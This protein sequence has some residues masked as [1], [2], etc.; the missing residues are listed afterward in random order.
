MSVIVRGGASG[1]R[2]RLLDHP[3]GA[4]PGQGRR[5]GRGHHRIGRGAARDRRRARGRRRRCVRGGQRHDRPVGR[6]RVDGRDLPAH[7]AAR[8]LRVPP[9]RRV[10]RAVARPARRSR[11]RPTPPARGSCPRWPV[12]R[13]ACCSASRPRS[14]RSSPTRPTGTSPDLPL[15]ERVAAPAHPGG[16]RRHPGRAGATGPASGAYLLAS[17]HKLFPLGDP[18]D[19]EPGPERS[20][21]AIAARE[22]RS[23]EE[24]T[25]DLMLAARRHRA[26]VLPAA[27]LHRR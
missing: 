15:P 26:A 19:Y 1:R 5:A 20:V 4:A 6:V 16:A 3:H 8:H 27:R 2:G 9:E 23:P 13:P 17:F 18:P 12:V 24:V 7:R 11:R 25:Y 10:A 14:T 21:A 22:G